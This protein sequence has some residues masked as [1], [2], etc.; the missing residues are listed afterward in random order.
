M[1]ARL[2]SDRQLLE[3]E[4][5][6][7]WER[8]RRGR[9]LKSA[10]SNGGRA[11][12]LVVAIAGDG[13]IPAFGANLSDALTN[14]I[15]GLLS[16]KRSEAARAAFIPGSE[17]WPPVI[18]DLRQRL[19]SAVGSVEV[20][21]GPSY[22]CEYAPAV[23]SLAGL[24]RSDDATA[25]F[26]HLTPPQDANWE[27]W[28]WELLLNGKLGPWAAMV[29]SREVVSLCFCARLTNSAVEAG[30]RTEADHRRRGYGA[31]VTAAWAAQVL[32]TGRVAFYS[33]SADNLASQAVAAR[34]GLR[35][36]GWRWQLSRASA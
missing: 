28:E 22:V 15:N 6:T 10:G 14:E 26:S 8:D 23:P 4:I 19:S 2:L 18:Q 21:S 17:R 36:I 5:E 34:L 11:P 3:L 32:A 24:I 9:L 1:D 13:V 27:P 29:A 35:P 33:T 30:L 31:A 7:L 16:A 20:A 12:D 25:D